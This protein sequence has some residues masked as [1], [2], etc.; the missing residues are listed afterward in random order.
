MGE[1]WSCLCL[2]GGQGETEAEKGEM[3]RGVRSLRKQ[4]GWD[5]EPR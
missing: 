2:I 3:M 5:P 1:I 4:R